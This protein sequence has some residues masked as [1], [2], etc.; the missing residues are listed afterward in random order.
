MAHVGDDDD[1]AR[2]S[3]V[4]ADAYSGIWASGFG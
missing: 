4:Y 1:E 2:Y 3:N